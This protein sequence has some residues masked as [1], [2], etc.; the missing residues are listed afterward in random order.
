MKYPKYSPINKH[1]LFRCVTCG[2][3]FESDIFVDEYSL[4]SCQKHA[5][6]MR[7]KEIVTKKYVIDLFDYLSNLN[8]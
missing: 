7:D 3:T 8:E 5:H 2:S 6:E 1:D 4:P